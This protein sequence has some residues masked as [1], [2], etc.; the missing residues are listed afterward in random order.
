VAADVFTVFAIDVEAPTA[1]LDDP[2]LNTVW[3]VLAGMLDPSWITTKASVIG[4]GS[5]SL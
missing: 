1:P 4:E 3:K 5:V 2:T